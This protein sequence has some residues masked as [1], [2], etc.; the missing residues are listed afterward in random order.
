MRAAIVMKGLLLVAWLPAATLAGSDADSGL[1]YNP[2]D[3]PSI[4]AEPVVKP[5]PAIVEKTTPP[6][7]KGT[8]VSADT[9]MAILDD[10]LLQVGEEHAGF[11]LVSVEE[12][13]AVFEHDGEEIKVL[14]SDSDKKA[15]RR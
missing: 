4:L 5:A 2:F 6:P 14:I 1:Q 7:L 3:K 13:A 12:G 11:R 10:T 9:P 8:L 15:G